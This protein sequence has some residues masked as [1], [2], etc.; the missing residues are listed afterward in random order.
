MKALAKKLFNHLGYDIRRITSEQPIANIFQI[1]FTTLMA[2]KQNVSVVQVGANDGMLNDP[3]YPMMRQFADRAKI[4]LI[5]PQP[6]LIPYLTE[7]YQFH[8]SALIH[9]VAIGDNGSLDLYAI[10]K[11]AWGALDV[12]YAKDWPRYRAP[13][14]VTSGN[15]DHVEAWLARHYR[16]KKSL[17]EIVEKLSVPCGPL[18]P[19]LEENGWERKIDVLQVDAEGYDDQVIYACAVTETKPQL[20]NFEWHSIQATGRSSLQSYLEEQGYVLFLNGGD[21]LAVAT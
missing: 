6:A 19:L 10:K 7:N 15:R 4:M 13:T 20:I 14:G 21:M 3:L 16:G 11:D 12:P 2:S 17:D 18:L 8:P 1:A 9:N 5:E